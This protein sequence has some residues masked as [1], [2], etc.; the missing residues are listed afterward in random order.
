MRALFWQTVRYGLVGLSA[1]AVDW[2]GF[3]ALTRSLPFF[4]EQYLLANVCSFVVAVA[5]AYTMHRRVTFRVNHGSHRAQ[6]P[7]FL[8]VTLIGLAINSLVLYLGISQ[9]GLYDLV[10]KVIALVMTAV[11]NF[12]GQKLWTF[13]LS[14][15]GSRDGLSPAPGGPYTG[16]VDIT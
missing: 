3:F 2:L 9:F 15:A 11:W 4:R 14:R 16:P 6:F 8:T 7:K 1:T 13:R 5:W 10:A 12:A